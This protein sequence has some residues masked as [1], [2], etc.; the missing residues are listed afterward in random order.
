[1]P[2]SPPETPT[3]T[4]FLA[5]SGAIVV[6]SPSATSAILVFQTSLPVLAS[7]ATV[8][9]IQQVVNDLS[10]GQDRPV[11]D[12]VAAGLADRVE[13]HVRAIFPTQRITVFREIEGVEHIRPRRDHV[14]RVVGHQG[15][16]LVA[17]EHAGGE[18]PHRMKPARVL[19]VD[20]VEFAE[21]GRG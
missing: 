3:M 7:T 11:I 6:V 21:P 13:A 8:W 14:H 17:A 1:M 10:V 5:T 2:Y 4:R 12:A 18:R 16:P 9:A 19:R 15:L 20:L